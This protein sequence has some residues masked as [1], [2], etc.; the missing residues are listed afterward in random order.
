[1]DRFRGYIP[2]IIR[3]P[4]GDGLLTV[5]VITLSI[6]FVGTKLLSNDFI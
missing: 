2:G 1:M 3:H 5:A 6:M 4:V